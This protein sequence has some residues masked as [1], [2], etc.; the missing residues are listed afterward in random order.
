MHL[1]LSFVMAV[2]AWV[3]VTEAT[4]QDKVNLRVFN[5]DFSKTDDEMKSLLKQADLEGNGYKKE[6][7]TQVVKRPG[8]KKPNYQ[9]QYLYYKDVTCGR[10]ME[11]EREMDMLLKG[12]L[13]DALLSK[14]HRLM[15]EKGLD[16]DRDC[17]VGVE[18]H[19]RKEQMCGNKK[20]QR[21]SPGWCGWRCNICSSTEVIEN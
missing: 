3:A 18:V 17:R 12:A 7:T 19:F 16:K 4:V 6:V 5:K 14:A 13:G 15:K 9:K 21:R 10:V 11:V 1:K 2:V 8:Q 20:R